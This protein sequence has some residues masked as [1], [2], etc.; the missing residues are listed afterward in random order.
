MNAMSVLRQKYESLK[1]Q[2]EDL[3]HMYNLFEARGRRRQMQRVPARVDSVA[4][5]PASR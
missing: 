5:R 1:T 4:A 3:L 2:L